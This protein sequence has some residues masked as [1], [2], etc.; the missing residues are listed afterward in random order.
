M[1]FVSNA[2]SQTTQKKNQLEFSLGY[3]SGTLKNLELAPVASYEYNDMVYKLNYE[4]TSEKQNIFEVEMDF[5]PKT[6][7]KTDR[8]T[9]FN[10]EYLKAGLGLS[11]LKKL[12]QKDSFTIHLGL[13]SQSTTSFYYN[14][15]DYFV[16]HQE[17]GIAGRF[18]YLLNEK[19]Y[20]SSKLT[21]PFILG[22]VGGNA[23]IRSFNRYQSILWNLKYGYELSEHFDLKITYDFIYNRLQLP[24]AYRELQHQLNIGINFKF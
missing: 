1:F 4:R 16:L 21:I 6:E 18:E 19:Q 17:F 3:N 12:Y 24:S 5:L 10:T 22:R 13:Q 23:T 9:V 2:F 8:L 7:I 20:L 14:K 11:Y 15:S